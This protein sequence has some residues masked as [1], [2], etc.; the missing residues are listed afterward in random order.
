MMID[1]LSKDSVQNA[2]YDEFV[3]LLQD[4]VIMVRLP[5]I[6]GLVEIMP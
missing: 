4:D 5:I 2:F 6:E 3:E 1:F